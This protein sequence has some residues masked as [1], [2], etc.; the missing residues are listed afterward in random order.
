MASS[1][2][3]RGKSGE[4]LTTNNARRLTYQS[5]T[6]THRDATKEITPANRSPG[7][8]VQSFDATLGTT[9]GLLFPSD[10]QPAERSQAMP[11]QDDFVLSRLMA[12]RQRRRDE[13]Y[14]LMS[15]STKS[16]PP[17]SFLHP[18]SE[19]ARITRTGPLIQAYCTGSSPLLSSITAARKEAAE[20]PL[21]TSRSSLARE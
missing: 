8:T 12:E 9:H 10:V 21:P 15:Q 18:P 14:A 7:D 16:T 20:A 2:K 1:Q 19:S 11:Q 4:S 13:R 17:R 3:R 5:T 6:N